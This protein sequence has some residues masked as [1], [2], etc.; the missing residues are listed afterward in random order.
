MSVAASRRAFHVA[1]PCLTGKTLEGTE[2]NFDELV[3]NADHPVIVDFYADWC[4]P[5][6]VLGPL[7]TKAVAANPTVTLVKVNVDKYQELATEFNIAALPTVMAFQN[8]EVADQ[9]VGMRNGAAL[10]EFVKK[11]ASSA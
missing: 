5:C 6:K 4:G 10:Q 7:L 11:H 9:F 3:I 1:R 8:G 2:E